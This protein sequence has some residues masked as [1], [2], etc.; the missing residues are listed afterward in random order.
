M[1]CYGQVESVWPV[2]GNV[3]VQGG[4]A[5]FVAGRSSYLDGGM[6]LY[7][8]DAA[9][10]QVLAHQNIDSRDPLTGEERPRS[11]RGVSMEGALPD[12]LSSNGTSIFLAA[13]AL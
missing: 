1:V 3:L 10:G 7:R 4:S 12:V 6:H 2:P 13:P 5:Y 11:I 9:T 8:L